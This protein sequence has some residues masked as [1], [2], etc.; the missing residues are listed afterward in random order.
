VWVGAY[1]GH[2]RR[3][4]ALC[5]LWC[6][7]TRSA[8]VVWRSRIARDP[9]LRTIRS[10]GHTELLRKCRRPADNAKPDGIPMT[11]FLARRD[12][13]TAK[14][15][16]PPARRRPASTCMQIQR[17]FSRSKAKTRSSGQS[18]PGN[19]EFAYGTK[20]SMQESH[21]PC[22]VRP[23]DKAANP[24]RRLA[25][26]KPLAARSRI[27][28][29]ELSSAT[30][31]KSERP[32]TDQAQESIGFPWSGSSSSEKFEEGSRPWRTSWSPASCFARC[33]QCA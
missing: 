15:S 11:A 29:V 30:K 22:A 24:R 13:T 6:R 14:N 10:T 12:P 32:V 25:P 20:S 31:S 28:A 21:H 18:T 26:S 8:Q 27:L 2:S 16:S 7:R 9:V 4:C 1:R 3:H 5:G 19:G 23:F 17:Q 33:G